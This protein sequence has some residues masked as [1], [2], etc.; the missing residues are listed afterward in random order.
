MQSKARIEEGVGIVKVLHSADII[1]SQLEGSLIH[2]LGHLKT[3][4][5]SFFR[6]TFFVLKFH[7]LSFLYPI[8]SFR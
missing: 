5:V 7:H 1:Q 8:A 2:V 3:G 6:I 4:Q